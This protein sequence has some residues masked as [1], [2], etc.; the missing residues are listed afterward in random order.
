MKQFR[1]RLQ[2]VLNV[3]EKREESAQH[4]L[5]IARSREEE[6]RGQLKAME[7]TW[8]AWEAKLRREQRGALDMKRLREHSDMLRRLQRQIGEQRERLAEAERLAAA[9]RDALTEVA[10]ERRTLERMREKQLARHHA[11]C[12]A[13]EVKSADDLVTTRLAANRSA[14]HENGAKTP[15]R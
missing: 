5:V 1:F 14:G 11:A 6:L 3:A 10:K 4:D 7:R 13:R 8:L 2:P 12:A 9:R 15:K